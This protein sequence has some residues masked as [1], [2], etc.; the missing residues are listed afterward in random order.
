MRQLIGLVGAVLIL[1]P[2]A[3]SQLGR[4][5]TATWTYQVMNFVGASLLTWVAV[6][7]RQYGFILV[8]GVW[9]LMSVVGMGRLWVGARQAT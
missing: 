6:L 7:E 5:R 8:E 3:G 1:V 2:F 4:L 9:A